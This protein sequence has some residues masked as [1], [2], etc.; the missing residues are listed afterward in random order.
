VHQKSYQNI[1][2]KESKS[3]K[4]PMGS[5]LLIFDFIDFSLPQPFLKILDRLVRLAM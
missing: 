2:H 5:G 1:S 4:G 3:I